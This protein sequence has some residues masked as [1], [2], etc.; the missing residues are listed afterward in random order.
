MTAVALPMII[1]GGMG[2]AVS[3]WKLAH[4]VSAFGQLGVV[5]GTAIDTVLV[6][7][8]QDGDPGGAVRRALAHFP[9]KEDAAEILRRYFKPEGRA[10]GEPY[11]T[12]PMYRQAVS[13]FREKVTIAANFVEVWLAKEGHHGKVGI[14]LLTKVQM[15]NLASLYGAML[16]GV[17]VVLMGAGIPR[18]IPGALDAF[19][20]HATA[21]IKLDV[22][23]QTSVAPAHLSFDPAAHGY[24]ATPLRR[25]EFYAI[26]AS[27]SLAANLARKATGTVNGFVVEGPTAGGHNAPPRGALQLNERG[28]P[29]YGPRDEV[30]L[31]AMRSLG[32]PFWLAG[33]AG[34]PE[35]LAAAR[36]EGAAGIQVGTAFAYSDESGFTPQIKRQ[37]LAAVAEGRARVHTDPDA[38]PTGFPFK[39]VQGTDIAQQDDT[40]ERCC[41]LGYLRTAAQREDG[42]L[43][44]R[45]SAAP[46][47][48][49]V[50]SGGAV[51]DTLRRRCLC[52]GLMS[53][54][55]LGQVREGG[56]VEPP[57]ITSGDHVRDLNAIAR[58]RLSY[59]ARDVLR[60]LLG[61]CAAESGAAS[62]NETVAARY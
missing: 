53:A 59:A 7:R 57:I 29:I 8:L 4:A 62:G 27:H 12:L 2:I 11:A 16:A 26:V 49:F 50:H 47:R 24:T 36:H 44:Y 55:G 48:Q 33:G 21:T 32:V 28:E 41:D 51:E 61:E 22:E 52:N 38:S 37:V 43:D 5:S 42:R 56:A 1:Q 10:E 60:Y 23:G 35:G 20:V 31:D 15:P 39:V 18:E 3:N 17:D 6:R 34:S 13:A 40:R 30:D 25:P 9:S 58:G 54:I 46:V 45:C 19:A 14:N